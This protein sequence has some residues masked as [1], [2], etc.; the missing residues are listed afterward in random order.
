MT[1]RLHDDGFTRVDEGWVILLAEGKRWGDDIYPTKDAAETV[2]EGCVSPPYKVV[3]AKRVRNARR[4][5]SEWSFSRVEP[6]PSVA[7]AAP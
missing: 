5:G 1:T 3:P 4:R 7:E 6:S 2:A